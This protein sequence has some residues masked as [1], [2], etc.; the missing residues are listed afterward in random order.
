[1]RTFDY[2][3]LTISTYFGKARRPVAN[4]CVAVCMKLAD[5]RLSMRKD[6]NLNDGYLRDSHEN[7]ISLKPDRYTTQ[8]KQIVSLFGELSHSGFIFQHAS[9]ISREAAMSLKNKPDLV[10]MRKEWPYLSEREKIKALR[11]I[12][13]IMTNILNASD[14]ALCLNYPTITLAK[15]PE[16]SSQKIGMQVQHYMT[17]LRDQTLAQISVNREGLETQGFNE[18]VSMLWHEHMHMY[19]AALRDCYSAGF[20][21]SRSPLYEDAERSFIIHQCNI[22]GNI[23]LS[24]EIYR[25]EPEEKLCYFTQDVFYKT[26]SYQPPANN[27]KFHRG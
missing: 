19:M 5:I 6:A 22:V 13:E 7:I 27:I 9:A 12:S 26:F 17:P 4:P 3:G 11:D 21:D 1:M 2:T 20:I 10:K 14:Q 15:F 16:A 18:A 8:I 25:A 23:N 24:D